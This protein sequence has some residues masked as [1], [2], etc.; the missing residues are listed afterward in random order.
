[1]NVT[2]IGLAVG[3]VLGLAAAFGGFSAFAIVAVIGALG[4]GVGRYLDGHL[5]LADLFGTGH[6]R[7]PR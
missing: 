5:D 2:L 6:E 1:M 7:V 3:L 4:F